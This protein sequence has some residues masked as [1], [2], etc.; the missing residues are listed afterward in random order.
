LL[1]PAERRASRSS[2]PRP[3]PPVRAAAAASEPTLRFGRRALSEREEEPTQKT[4]AAERGSN[5]NFNVRFQ[6]SF[7]RCNQRRPHNFLSLFDLS[8]S[9]WSLASHTFYWSLAYNSHR[10]SLFD[11]QSSNRRRL[12]LF[13][14]LKRL[15]LHSTPLLLTSTVRLRSRTP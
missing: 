2:E 15:I 14:L 12:T 3:S 6:V 9:I 1:L 8:L 10:K 11:R 13:D 5:L 4:P 7:H